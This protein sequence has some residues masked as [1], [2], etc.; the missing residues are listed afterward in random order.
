METVNPHYH[1][2]IPKNDPFFDKTDI[3]AIDRYWQNTYIFANLVK[4]QTPRHRTAQQFSPHTTERLKGL[5]KSDI[6]HKKDT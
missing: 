5:M 6:S 1:N 3:V 4:I 2:E